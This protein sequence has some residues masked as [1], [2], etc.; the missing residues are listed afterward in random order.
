[1]SSTE[2]R[3]SPALD[4]ATAADQHSL[5]KR[6]DDTPA[7]T[8]HGNGNGN[9]SVAGVAVDDVPETLDDVTGP[10]TTELEF[11]DPLLEEYGE[12][13]PDGSAVPILTLDEQEVAYGDL[14][15]GDE[16]ELDSHFPLVATVG[17]E[18]TAEYEEDDPEGE[19]EDL[20]EVVDRKDTRGKLKARKVRRVVR[21]VSPWS[22]LKVSLLFYAC[23]WVIVTIAS[24]ILWRVA[25]ETGGIANVEKFVARLFGEKSFTID[26]RE[27]LRASTIAGVI[28]VF[29]G[30][31]FTVLM[32]LLFNVICDITGGIRF[33]VLE[34]ETTKRRLRRRAQVARDARRYEAR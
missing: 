5:F 3:L 24:V 31:G 1:V 18:Q 28:L 34:L 9:G 20:V 15:A 27:I 25:V 10:H 11:D 16:S 8:G 33:T 22:V 29:A 6:Q 19:Y 17:G 14:F 32:S 23:L 13:D 12:G 26:G 7:A 21:Y 4:P 30:T 2:R